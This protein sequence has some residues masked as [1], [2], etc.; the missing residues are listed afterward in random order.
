MDG[1]L[2]DTERLKA[3]AY[4]DIVAELFKTD[5]PDPRVLPLYGSFVGSTDRALCEEMVE[6]FGLSE[7]L[8]PH[9]G[10]LGV[11]APWEALHTMRMDHYHKTY[12]RP[13]IIAQNAFR[14]TVDMVRVQRAAGRIVAVATSSSTDE[15]RRVLEAIGVLDPLQVVVGRDQVSHA[16]PH[17]EIYLKTAEALGVTP[18]ECIVIEDSPLGARSALAAEMACLV[19]ANQFTGG[20]LRSFDEIDQRWVAYEPA[21]AGMLLDLLIEELEEPG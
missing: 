2:A 12:G 11:S 15:A 17:P 8:I 7:I 20:P 6:Q 1:T 16:K 3:R 18:S 9:V 19:V 4:T 13:E 14:H 21:E 10:R 5:D